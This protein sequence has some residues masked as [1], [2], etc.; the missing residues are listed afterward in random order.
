MLDCN[1]DDNDYDDD[2]E[3]ED[4]DDINTFQIFP[5]E[6]TQTQLISASTL[7]GQSSQMPP[8]KTYEMSA[9]PN[10]STDLATCRGLQTKTNSPPFLL[11]FQMPLTQ[12]HT[13]I[14][15]TPLS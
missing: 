11:L 6:G 4:G 12:L 13:K 10:Q 5:Q 2:D 1:C 3:E 8:S 9:N 14:I 7:F 15:I